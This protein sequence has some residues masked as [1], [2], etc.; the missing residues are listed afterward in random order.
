MKTIKLLLLLVMTIVTQGVWAQAGTE[1]EVTKPSGTGQLYDAFKINTPAEFAWFV[2]HSNNASTNADMLNATL[3]ADLDMT[4][5]TLDPICQNKTYSCKFEGGDHTIK[6]LKISS[7]SDYC[8][9]FARMNR[10][11]VKGLTIEDAEVTSTGNYVGILCGNYENLNQYTGGIT[12]INSTVKG[13]DYVGG[14]FGEVLET[15]AYV[16]TISDF[17][18]DENCVVNGANN[19]GG[20]CGYANARIQRCIN[21]ASVTGTENVGGIMGAGSWNENNSPGNQNLNYGTIVGQTYVGGIAG[22]VDAITNGFFYD[23]ANLGTITGE[24]YVGGLFGQISNINDYP[25]VKYA[26]VGKDLVHATAAEAHIGTVCGDF[27]LAPDL[28]TEIDYQELFNTIYIESAPIGKDLDIPSLNQVTHEQMASGEVAYVLT[29]TPNWGQS[30]GRDEYPIPV[31]DN[32]HP[33]VAR[34]ETWNCLGELISISYFNSS[35]S[36]NTKEK[37]HQKMEQVEYVEA[38]CEHHGMNAHYY[39]DDCK[40]HYWYETSTQPSD[41]SYFIISRYAHTLYNGVCQTC[42]YEVRTIELTDNAFEGTVN[43]DLGASDSYGYDYS[44][45]RVYIPQHGLLSATAYVDYEDSWYAVDIQEAEYW[46]YYT[47]ESSDEEDEPVPSAPQRRAGETNRSIGLIDYKVHEGYYY[48]VVKNTEPVESKLVVTF[49][50]HS[51]VCVLEHVEP[52]CEAGLKAVFHCTDGCDEYFIT[53]DGEELYWENGEVDPFDPDL[54]IPGNGHQL[55]D[56]GVCV[57]CG[58]KIALVAGDNTVTLSS[59]SVFK[60]LATQSK[61]LVISVDTEAEISGVQIMTWDKWDSSS[62]DEEIQSAP[63]RTT[64]RKAGSVNGTWRKNVKEGETYA[65]VITTACSEGA[66]AAAEVTLSYEEP[67]F[68]EVFVG[69]NSI[70]ILEKDGEGNDNP[71]S[72]NLFKFVAPVSGM[73]HFYTQGDADT[74]GQLFNESMESISGCE[75][76]YYN[77]NFNIDYSVTQGDTYYIGARQYGGREIGYYTLVIEYDSEPL[78]LATEDSDGNVTEIPLFDIFD[79]SDLE[80]YSIASEVTY[81]RNVTTSRWGTVILPY[82]LRS[83]DVVTYYKLASASDTDEAGNAVMTFSPVE[84]VEPNTPTVYRFNQEAS[85]YQYDASTTEQTVI[86]IYRFTKQ[87]NTDLEGWFMMGST[88][89]QKIYD[90]SEIL[91]DIRY[92]S[93]DQFMTATK[94]LT[95]NPYRAIFIYAGNASAPARTFTLAIEGEQPEGIQMV[96]TDNGEMAEVEAIY[97]VNGKRISQLQKGLNLVRTTDG[98]THKIINK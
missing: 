82:E 27:S 6:N 72:Y 41:E 76:D 62:D 90:N 32:Y 11:L 79:T 14:V 9:L 80:E 17:E 94:K 57:V 47:P 54:I 56:N 84:T 96:V 98:K 73:A 97:D 78:I 95:I 10:A 33:V 67:T 48:I 15:T 16:N 3:E 65:I 85:S 4:G 88:Y 28:N 39:C 92:I 18:T 8:G 24:D 63:I 93:H 64:S 29:N 30:I 81:K 31:R 26:I 7:S 75:D 50:P 68:P 51:M 40:K 5:Y 71:D 61:Q 38:T 49:T 44:L 22:Y 55:N 69:E 59:T 12:I 13:K 91:Q 43:Y 60:H 87:I 23:N 83:N 25:L 35:Y 45:F 34:K 70:E 74:Y 37:V 36:Y 89:E 19:V 52:T 86:Y 53:E 58:K 1:L 77:S 21:R 66:S 46:E 42:G 2:K 20:I